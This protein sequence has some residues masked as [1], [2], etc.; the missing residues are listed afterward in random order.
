[1]RPTWANEEHT[2]LE[3]HTRHTRHASVHKG[4]WARNVEIHLER[5][6]RLEGNMRLGWPMR[7]DK[8]R[9]YLKGRH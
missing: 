2:R 6:T 7:C 3:G 1:M 5:H 4:T 8:K 9:D